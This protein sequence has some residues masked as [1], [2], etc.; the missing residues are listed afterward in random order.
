MEERRRS[1]TSV[2]PRPEHHAVER[3]EEGRQDESGDQQSLLHDVQSR[4]PD[5]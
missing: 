2:G 5:A 3:E 4:T 1:E